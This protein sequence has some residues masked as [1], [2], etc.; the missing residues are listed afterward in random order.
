MFIARRLYCGSDT[1]R[2]ASRPAVVIA[3]TGIAVGLA[4]MLISVAVVIGFKGEV[5]DKLVGFSSHIRIS[6][7]SMNAIYESKP[8]VVD[9]TLTARLEG[10]PGVKHLQRYAL[11]AGMVKTDDAFQG[12]VLK[13]V[14]PEYDLH[15][16]NDHLV[17]GE[18]PQFSDSASLNRVVISQLLADRMQLKLGDKLDTYFIED[19]VKARR[20]EVVGIYCTHFAEYD[21]LF[22]FTDLYTV[23]RLN[24]WEKGQVS[25]V[26]LELEEYDRLEEMTYLIADDLSSVSDRYG[27][28]Y[29]VSNVEMMNP[30]MFAWLEILD[31]N[32]WVILLLMTGVAGFTMISGLLIL[33]I[34]RTSMIGLLKSLGAN[35]LTLRR[36]FLWLAVFLIGRGMFWGNLVALAFIGVQH[37]FGLFRLDPETYYMD[38]VPVVFHPLYYLLLNLAAFVISVAMLVGPSYLIA[39]IHPAQSMRYE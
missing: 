15:F 3:M 2:E 26:E 27:Q 21:Q 28:R 1:A 34:E 13:G 31:V 12:M 25:G 38:T 36:L 17:A 16:L 24:R 37:F 8:V 4:V 10:M 23:N 33:I 32:I 9:D 19:K 18:V 14:G 5:R 6:N 22:L 29:A 35:N 30:Q 7:L 20:L 39:R 11:R